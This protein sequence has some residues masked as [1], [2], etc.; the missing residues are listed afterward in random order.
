MSS[1]SEV[2]ASLVHFAIGKEE[3]RG[4]GE[5]SRV[6]DRRPRARASHQLFFAGRTR[7]EHVTLLGDLAVAR[8]GLRGLGH[9]FGFRVRAEAVVGAAVHRARPHPRRDRVLPT[10]TIELGIRADAVSV[11]THHRKTRERF[12]PSTHDAHALR[13]HPTSSAREP[14]DERVPQAQHPKSLRRLRNYA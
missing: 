8:Q 9:C 2:S 13:R 10:Q 6:A 7:E 14:D 4:F 1:T 5:L 11:Q 12:E 3:E